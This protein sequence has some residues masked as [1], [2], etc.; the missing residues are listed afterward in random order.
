MAALPQSLKAAQRPEPSAGLTFTP[1]H[2]HS[3][4]HIQACA[5]MSGSGLAPP[6]P[7]KETNP[8]AEQVLG[9]QA[10]VRR[11]TQSPVQDRNGPARSRQEIH[12]TS[13]PVV[14]VY[15]GPG[16]EGGSEP[17]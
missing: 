14:A 13:V 12:W 11:D 16:T 15:V 7:P 1:A 3:Q 5:Q 17:M 10:Q 6:L 8:D 4:A 9:D 2:A